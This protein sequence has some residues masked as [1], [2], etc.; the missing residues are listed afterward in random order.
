MS[1][2][3]V[4]HNLIDVLVTAMQHLAWRHNSEG[5]FDLRWLRDE[6]DENGLDVHV[7]KHVNAYDDHAMTAEGIVLICTVYDS[8][9]ARYE[10]LAGKTDAEIALQ[11]GYD[12]EP[13]T[14]FLGKVPGTAMNLHPR[15]LG[16]ASV[17]LRRYMENAY[18]APNFDTS[19]AHALC[20]MLNS[21]LLWE[22][23]HPLDRKAP[24]DY[25]WHGAMGGTLIDQQT[26]VNEMAALSASLRMIAQPIVD[27]AEAVEAGE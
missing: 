16:V 26:L 27:H 3:P 12:T 25:E 21:W 4:N 15:A 5:L 24:A 14:Y 23:V 8:L 11:W 13:Y 10:D 7:V 19:R 2:Q 9:R 20:C 18:Q 17:A 6:P 22:L 1:I